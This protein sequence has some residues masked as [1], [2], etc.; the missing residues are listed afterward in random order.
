[1]VQNREDFVEEGL[2]GVK[3][4]FVWLGFL[5]VLGGWVLGILA[6]LALF[7]LGLFCF[8][9]GVGLLLF[10]FFIN[11]FKQRLHDLFILTFKYLCRYKGVPRKH[12]TLLTNLL[13]L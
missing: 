1:M 7:F 3:V 12:V 4:V 2:A 11:H 5:L 6:W 8:L 10:I 13:Y 9:I